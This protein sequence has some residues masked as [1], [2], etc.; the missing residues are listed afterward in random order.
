MKDGTKW[1]VLDT[2]TDGLCHPIHIVEIAAQRMIDDQTDG[3]PFQ[4][5]LNHG[6]PI[7]TAAYAV[8]GYSQSFLTKNGA[9]PHEAYK[10][11]REYIGDRF[12]C[13]HN[14]RYDWSQALMPEWARLGIEPIGQKGFCT[15]M[16]SKRIVRE[17]VSFR[18]DLLRRHYNLNCSKAHSA[19]GDV[20]SVVDLLSTHLL[21]QLHKKQITSFEDV[22]EFS[23]I[24]PPIKAT[25][26]V[27]GMDYA[28]IEG[29]LKKDKSIR[30]E[31]S[32][33]KIAYA[34]A[35]ILRKKLEGATQETFPK[36]I[37][38]Y[39]FIEDEPE[40]EFDG[41]HFLFTGKLKWGVR[42][43][44]LEL[45]ESLGGI[46]ET[47]KSI[48][49]RINYLVLGEDEKRGWTSHIFGGKLNTAF[50][51]KFENPDRDF[52]LVLEEDFFAA[53]NDYR[54]RN[55]SNSVKRKKIQF[56]DGYAVG[57]KMAVGEFFA[58][59]MSSKNFQ[60]GDT[61]YDT[62]KAYIGTWGESLK[63]ISYGFQVKDKTGDVIEYDLLK[64]NEDR[65][66]LVK[67]STVKESID[68]F[69]SKLEKGI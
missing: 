18:L 32:L 17:L 31:N 6:V 60:P 33:K 7:P 53:V 5:F 19:L 24:N 42:K 52:H 59:T 20:E 29:T 14:M 12:V 10:Q 22:L 69:M 13:C 47:S 64:P 37:A 28:Q 25:C 35:G 49:Q 62:P 26:L 9:D 16:L 63:H 51:G 15:W 30:Y 66:K 34:S 11:L 41:K 57:F 46:P 55:G 2:E 3:E 65:T 61:I 1:I 36:I 4:I 54:A 50:I 27:H 8:H 39:E 56:Q 43:N 44:V 58:K 48:N 67:D 45:V 23:R 21:P 40:I 68:E 38:E